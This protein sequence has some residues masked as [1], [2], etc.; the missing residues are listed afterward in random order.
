MFEQWG[1]RWLKYG[2]AA[3]WFAYFLHTESG[4]VLLPQG[5]KQRPWRVVYGSIVAVLEASAE[6]RS[7]GRGVAG[8][9]PEHFDRTLRA[10]YSG[11]LASQDEE[12]E[13]SEGTRRAECHAR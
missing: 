5:V 4:Q 11:S 7:E 2:S 3:G 13:D 12:G 8:C 9:V 10:G 1:S 6:G